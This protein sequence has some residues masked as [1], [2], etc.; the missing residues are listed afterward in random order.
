M[1]LRRLTSHPTVAP[2]MARKEALAQR[3]REMVESQQHLQAVLRDYESAQV[4]ALAEQDLDALRRY[5][6]IKAQLQECTDQIALVDAGLAELDMQIDHSMGSVREQVQAQIDTLFL[7]PT[8]ALYHGLQALVADNNRLH[9]LE[10]CSH[11]L[12][13]TGRLELYN[14]GLAG[15]LYRLE[16]KLALVAPK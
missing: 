5:D 1:N 12:L 2:L 6:D 14:A 16:R 4:L 9:E 7:E 13:Q 8:Q 15:W 10:R 11:R 3:R